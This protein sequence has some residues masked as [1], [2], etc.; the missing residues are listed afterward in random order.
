VHNPQSF[1]V[2]IAN[3]KVRYWTKKYKP[4]KVFKNDGRVVVEIYKMPPGTVDE[5]IAAG[6]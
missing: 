3:D 1:R 5:I 2:S 4:D 6:Y